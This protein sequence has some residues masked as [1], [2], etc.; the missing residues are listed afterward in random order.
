MK[1]V[2]SFCMKEM[3]MSALVEREEG[4]MQLVVLCMVACTGN[5]ECRGAAKREIK[6]EDFTMRI[7]EGRISYCC[8]FAR[9][10]W[11]KASQAGEVVTAHL[12]R[13]RKY[14]WLFACM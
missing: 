6:K 11:E 4:K 3:G 9:E 1:G 5:R 2:L 10:N 13:K 8:Y 14:C 7:E 12:T